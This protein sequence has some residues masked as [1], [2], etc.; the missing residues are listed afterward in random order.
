MKISSWDLT[1]PHLLQLSTDRFFSV[2]GKQPNGYLKVCVTVIDEFMGLVIHGQNYPI[3]WL[4]SEPSF[5]S[6]KAWPA[7]GVRP[8]LCRDSAERYEVRSKK[9]R[10]EFLESLRRRAGQAAQGTGIVG[11]LP[12][13]KQKMGSHYFIFF[14]LF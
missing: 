6:G 14:I 2:N 5:S 7:K 9:F 3:V 13:T 10:K 12:A 8:L 11:L 4:S 1:Q